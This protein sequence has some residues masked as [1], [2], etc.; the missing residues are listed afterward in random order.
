MV[1]GIDREGGEVKPKR[2]IVG[3]VKPGVTF[4]CEELQ[5]ALRGHKLYH[6]I[7]V[8]CVGWQMPLVGSIVMRHTGCRLCG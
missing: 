1:R 5:E 3:K 7:P 4:Y 2:P 6:Q 8:K